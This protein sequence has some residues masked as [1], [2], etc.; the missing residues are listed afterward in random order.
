KISRV[1]CLDSVDSTNNYAKNLAL[2]GAAH[3]TL[4][5]SNEQTAGRGRRGHFFESPAGTGLYMSLI[6]RPSVDISQFQMIT[7]ADAVAVCLSIEDLYKGSK[8]QLKIKWV[9]DIFFHEKKITGILTE[10][11]TN[12]ESGEIESVVTGIGINISTK[13]FSEQAGIT[14]GSIF[15]DGEFLFSRS[16]L[17]AR[18][19]DYVMDFAEN[20]SDKKLINAYRERSLL[21]GKKITFMKN[22]EEHSAFVEGIDDT[23]GLMI[24]NEDGGK[25]ILR[26]GEV[27]SVR[28]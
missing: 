11:V 27:F 18:I 9:N 25:E 6:L 20:L 4:I 16:E 3:G 7:I 26:S 15:S 10:A 19:A 17:C 13:N 24:I 2:N 8:G 12:F 28:S 1:I 14:A 5:T 22:N 23:G 21:T